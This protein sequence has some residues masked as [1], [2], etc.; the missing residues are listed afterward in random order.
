MW[1]RRTNATAT[2]TDTTTTIGVCQGRCGRWYDEGRATFAAEFIVR[3]ARVPRRI[4]LH[5]YLSLPISLSLSRTTSLPIETT[6]SHEAY[7]STHNTRT[8]TPRYSR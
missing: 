1:R 2:A 4:I 3:R 8:N 5:I 6:I 7:R